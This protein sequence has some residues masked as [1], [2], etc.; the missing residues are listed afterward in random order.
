M[1]SL[2]NSNVSNTVTHDEFS[3]KKPGENI[4]LNFI[5]KSNFNRL[6]PAH[7]NIHSIRNKFDILN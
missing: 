5:R 4:N 2:E 6:V 7:I 3:A 1:R